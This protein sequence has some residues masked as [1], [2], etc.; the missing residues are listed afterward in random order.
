MK[1]T[2]Q[3]ICLIISALA[4]AVL[5]SH[6]GSGGGGVTDTH[7]VVETGNISGRITAGAGAVLTRDAGAERVAAAAGGNA[8]VY[9]FP[10]ATDD[11][12]LVPSASVPNTQTDSNGNYT[13]TNVPVGNIVLVVDYD[14][15]NIADEREFNVQV[16][17][18]ST[19]NVGTT[20]VA[21]LNKNP[22]GS[23]CDITLDK[24]NYAA[25]EV[26]TCP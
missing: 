22:K 26:I 4:I 15:D 8:K 9:A 7:A 24:V 12:D 21:A 3:R 11:K 14:N 2:I 6:C 17:K 20:E 10:A 19:T 5:T 13:I 25:G 1:D 18:G 16:S 23:W